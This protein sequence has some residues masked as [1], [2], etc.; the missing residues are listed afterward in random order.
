MVLGVHGGGR[1]GM[2]NGNG[3]RQRLPAQPPGA[4]MRACMHAG[5]VVWMGQHGGIITDAEDL[6]KVV[7]ALPNKPEGTR[8][9]RGLLGL[10]CASCAHV[11]A[12]S[13]HMHTG[14]HT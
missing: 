11:H 9:G 2:R 8:C 6:Q 3:W 1:D 13:I 14:A 10:N 5:H 12:Y 7:A 4:C